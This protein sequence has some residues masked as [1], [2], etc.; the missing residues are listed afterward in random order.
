M[1]FHQHLFFLKNL[2][3][4]ETFLK[5]L[6]VLAEVCSDESGLRWPEAVAPAK[7]HIVALAKQRTDE[8]FVKA[9]ELY[10]HLMQRGVA[11]V[12]DDRIE[13]SAGSRLAD[14]DLIGIPYRMLVSAKS[15]SSGGVERKN[16][17]TGDVDV[18]GYDEAMSLS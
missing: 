1:V 18:I 6:C 7:Y 17:W 10:A 12:F 8:A 5:L 2:I 13:Q 14:A 4:I 11:C 9:E 16:R 15:L 3:T